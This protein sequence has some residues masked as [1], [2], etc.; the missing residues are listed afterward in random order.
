MEDREE[1]EEPLAIRLPVEQLRQYLGEK[2]AQGP[3]EHGGLGDRAPEVLAAGAEQ[4]KR[5]HAHEGD[6]GMFE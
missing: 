3:G 1:G 6:Q 4:G 5:E 2:R